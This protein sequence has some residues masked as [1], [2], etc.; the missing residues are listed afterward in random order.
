[1]KTKEASGGPVLRTGTNGL[2]GGMEMD[3]GSPPS[4]HACPG[5]VLFSNAHEYKLDHFRVKVHRTF[6][7]SVS[8]ESPCTARLNQQRN[9]N[10]ASHLARKQIDLE[11]S[12]HGLVASK[13]GEGRYIAIIFVSAVLLVTGMGQV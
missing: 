7:T 6:F 12:R 13:S 11:W 3:S 9:K 1:M 10:R 5:A 8:I 4:L 2:Y